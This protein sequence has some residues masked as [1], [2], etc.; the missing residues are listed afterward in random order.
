MPRDHIVA[1]PALAEL[2]AVSEIAAF[3]LTEQTEGK[4]LDLS[5]LA[6]MPGQV[7]EV[8]VR[9]IKLGQTTEFEQLRQSV[10][11][12]LDGQPGVLGSYEFRAVLG[13][14]REG[15]TVGLSVYQDQATFQQLAQELMARENTGRYFA[16]FVP[17]ALKSVLAL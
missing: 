14:N 12:S 5:S 9:R 3:A 8:A 6:V 1:S 11:A 15:L 17:E 4:P 2:L 10:G 16:T 13:Q 7:L